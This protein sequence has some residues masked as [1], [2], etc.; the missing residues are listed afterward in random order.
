MGGGNSK[1]VVS[2]VDRQTFA[3][4]Q[5]ELDTKDIQPGTTLQEIIDMLSAYIRLPP[6]NVQI[7]VGKALILYVMGKVYPPSTPLENISVSVL[8]PGSANIKIPAVVFGTT[9]PVVNVFSFE[10]GD[11]QKRLSYEA[12]AE[13]PPKFARE[14][15]VLLAHCAKKGIC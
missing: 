3:V 13:R 7:P 6:F 1:R 8:A 11:I 2:F 10:I 5:F 4:Y 15:D 14:S 9:D 12:S